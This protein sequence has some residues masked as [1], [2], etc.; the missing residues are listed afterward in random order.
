MGL[1]QIMMENPT[2]MD[3]LGVTP[4]YGNLQM[5]SVNISESQ[6][7]DHHP[8]SFQLVNAEKIPW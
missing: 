4:I 6:F 5:A 2:Q 7:F 8:S 3:D 1:P